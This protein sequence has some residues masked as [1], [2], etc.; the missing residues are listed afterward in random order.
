MNQERVIIESVTP[1][2]EG[3]RYSIKRVV[4]E[5]IDVTATV[6]TDGHDI[7]QASLE[8]KHEKAR[9]WQEVQFD[10]RN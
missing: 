2:L 7:L 10:S 5:T 8:Y 3:G 6:L 1:Q 4:G 9:K